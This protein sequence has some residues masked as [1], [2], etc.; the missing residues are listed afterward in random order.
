[1]NKKYT[2]GDGLRENMIRD[3]YSICRLAKE[4]GINK[5][6]ISNIV[7]NKR[8]PSPAVRLLLETAHPNWVEVK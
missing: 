1:M 5:G 2:Y 4:L 3:G 7:N 8:D 6:I